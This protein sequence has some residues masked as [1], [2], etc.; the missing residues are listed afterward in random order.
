MKAPFVSSIGALEKNPAETRA[1]PEEDML[2]MHGLHQ[3][4]CCL[5]F[6]I[7]RRGS[8]PPC[9]STYPPDKLIIRRYFR[10]CYT[11]SDQVSHFQSPSMA[12][13]PWRFGF[14]VCFE[15]QESVFYQCLELA[16]F[17]QCNMYCYSRGERNPS[18]LKQVGFPQPQTG[19]VFV[20]AVT[21]TGVKMAYSMGDLWSLSKN[22]LKFFRCRSRRFVRQHFLLVLHVQ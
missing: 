18:V 2:F 19:H 16:I 22:L 15:V 1:A 8:I 9:L 6:Q 17:G 4:T 12:E 5:S 14:E 3:V 13:N 10:G 20:K 21:P 11:E 7:R